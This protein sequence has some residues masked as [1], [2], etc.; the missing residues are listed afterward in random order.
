MNF[1]EKTLQEAEIFKGKIIH[2]HHDLV[3]LPNGKEGHREVV[4]HPGGVM[5]A[6]LLANGNLIFV[7][8]YRYPFHQVLLELPAGKLEKGEDPREAGLR[9][10]AEEV[11]ATAKTVVS[12]GKI[13][14]TPGYCSEVIYLYLATDLTLGQQNPDEDEFLELV[15]YP[16]EQAVE[17][18]MNGTLSDAKTVAGVL[19]IHQL[20]VSG[21]L[22]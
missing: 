17:M 6:P 14:P 12:L 16:L 22:K 19:K 15:Q 18:V 4:E 11:G 1:E 9:E 10:L 7:R 8:Q 21:V 2:V 13:Y 5:M 3:Q 20:K